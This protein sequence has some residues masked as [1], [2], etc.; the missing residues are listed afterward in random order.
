MNNKLA[1]IFDFDGVLVDTMGLHF[2]CFK[3]AFEEAGM[4]IDH[5]TF[6]SQAGM[7]ELEMIRSF[8]EHIER[9]IDV[10]SIHQR[11]T[12]LWNENKPAE[13]IKTFDCNIRLLNMLRAGSI[14]VAIASG[15]S[16]CNIESIMERH[17]IEAD[18]VVTA[19]DV[20]RGKPSPDLFLYAAERLG[21]E[22][23]N[24]IVIEDSDAGVKAAL[25][26]GMKVFRFYENKI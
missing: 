22:P 23:G 12:E 3:Q 25:T 18:A 14:P 21:V 11:K 15:G 19:E 24:C 10:N 6:Y 1:Y 9:E 7:T 26:A 17:G 16:L 20:Q 5:A 13:R 4:S 2:Q 8:T